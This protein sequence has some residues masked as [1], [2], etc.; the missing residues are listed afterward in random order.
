MAVLVELH[1]ESEVQKCA[2]MTTP[3]RGV[4]NRNLHTF[5]VDL[6]QTIALCRSWRQHRGNRKRHHQQRRR[7]TDAAARREYLSYR[8]NLYARR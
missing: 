8:R 7:A 4:N 6:Q 5:E 3:L 1:D 2:R